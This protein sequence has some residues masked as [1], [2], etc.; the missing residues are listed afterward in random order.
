MT[1]LEEQLHAAGRVVA[2]LDAISDPS[3]AMAVIDRLGARTVRVV[4]MRV[5]LDAHPEQAE[6]AGWSPDAMEL[7]A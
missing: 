6:Q 7:A 4:L 2:H 3:E 1:G 5:W